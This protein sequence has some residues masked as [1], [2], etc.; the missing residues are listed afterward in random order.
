MSVRSGRFRTTW[1]CGF[2]TS[3]GRRAGIWARI[4]CSSAATPRW[5]ERAARRR[6]EPA[7]GSS[8]GLGTADFAVVGREHDLPALE[9]LGRVE[10]IA[11]GPTIRA[12]RSYWLFRIK[13]GI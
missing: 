6:L 9:R 11:R 12:D 3:A 1:R 5:G 10:V 7:P 2:S 13:P 8:S 4:R